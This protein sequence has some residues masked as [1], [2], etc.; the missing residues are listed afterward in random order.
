MRPM[1]PMATVLPTALPPGREA[2]PGPPLLQVRPTRRPYALPEF[3]DASPALRSD[4][5]PPGLGVPLTLALRLHDGAGQAIQRAAVYIWHYDPCCWL[6][7]A[8]DDELK[9]VAMMRG[10][11]LS[12]AD[13]HVRFHTVYPGRYRDHTVPVYL[14]VYFNDGRHVIARADACLLLPALAVGA[15]E[16]LSVAPPV[17]PSLRKPSFN[18]A[19]DAS[20]LSP[21]RLVAD[22]DSG[23]LRAELSIGISLDQAQP[24]H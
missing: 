12:D 13:G 3:V 16:E 5:A 7:D 17:P 1:H 10:V 19:G 11:Q 6:F 4:L 21:D 18:T 2:E 24:T 14:Q 23:G 20:T 8:G 9:A 15:A 22:P